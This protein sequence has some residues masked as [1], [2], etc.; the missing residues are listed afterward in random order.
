MNVHQAGHEEA[1]ARFD[2]RGS[3]RDGQVLSDSIDFPVPDDDR[4]PLDRALGDGQNRR[5]SND[6]YAG[7]RPCGCR[8][9]DEGGQRGKR[10]D[11]G[12]G[13]DC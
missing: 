7:A 9:R 2:D 8:Y 1:P 11:R 10:D 5:A 13:K 6:G 3:F 12:G 4:S